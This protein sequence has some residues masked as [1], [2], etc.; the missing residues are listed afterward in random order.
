MARQ[1][2]KGEQYQQETVALHQNVVSFAK[3]IDAVQ[4]VNDQSN[5]TLIDGKDFVG[6]F[7]DK[8][9]VIT[10]TNSKGVV[11]HYYG[12]KTT[13]SFGAANKKSKLSVRYTPYGLQAGGA[14]IPAGMIVNP[15]A[16]KPSAPK[17][18]LTDA[19]KAER[20][21]VKL[22][23]RLAKEQARYQEKV[24]KIQEKLNKA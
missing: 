13:A 23:E 21:K 11:K 22:Q 2:I 9:N 10:Q 7:L 19:E 4:R 3:G 16:G 12:L 20:A 14:F 1:F 15:D 24:A 5:V 18:K 17:E 6:V 8:S